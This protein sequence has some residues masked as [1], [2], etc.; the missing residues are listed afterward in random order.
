MQAEND[1]KA[2]VS[3]LAHFAEAEFG[4]VN[5][6]MLKLKNNIVMNTFVHTTEE[7]RASVEEG[8]RQ[9]EA[10]QYYTDAQVKR[11]LDQRNLQLA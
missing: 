2:K 6:L 7:L 10:G 3:S 1:S 11:M 5:L 4:N 9:V 8:T